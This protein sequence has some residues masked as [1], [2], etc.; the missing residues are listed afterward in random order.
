MFARTERLLLRP[1]WR[2]DAPALFQAICDQ[3][4]VC[5][6]ASAPWPYSF[7]DAQAFL[8]REPK[9]PLD[10]RWLITMRTES[11]P[12][13][14]GCIGFGN[15]PEDGLEFGY[16]IARP[17]WGQGIAT[18]AGRAVVDIA[19]RGLRLK[20]LQAGHFID[21]PASGRV[22]SK[23]GFRHTGTELRYSAGRA[24]E[25]P[26]KLFELDLQ[27]DEASLPSETAMAA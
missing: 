9:S 18:E 7:A 20:R 17:F 19:R 27:P 23:L 8:E 4:I 6:L 21:N 1:G 5:N 12:R 14:V 13:L 24:A 16:W 3:R 25:T 10:G 22:L 2:E 11:E 26:C 15:T